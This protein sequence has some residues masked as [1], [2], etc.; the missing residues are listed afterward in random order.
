MSSRKYAA[1]YLISHLIFILSLGVGL[2][3]IVILLYS[4]KDTYELLGREK[5][6]MK[7]MTV[8][9]TI[10]IGSPFTIFGYTSPYALVSLETRGFNQETYAGKD[11]YFKFYSDHRSTSSSEI[12]LSARDQLGRITA[13]TCIPPLPPEPNVIIGPIL[14]SPT[15]SLDKLSYFISDNIILTGQAI[16]NTVVQLSLF[17][18]FALPPI[19]VQADEG[20]NYAV[21]LPSNQDDKY[22]I[23]TRTEFLDQSSPKSNTLLFTINPIWVIILLFIKSIWRL[24]TSHFIEFIIVTELLIIIAHR[25]YIWVGKRKHR[26]E[27]ILYQP[28]PLSIYKPTSIIPYHSITALTTR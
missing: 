9:A 20:G 11:G 4:R 10:G 17:K 14:L 22:R 28:E 3:A 21:T 19:E 23:F 18:S 2:L 7:D 16:P 6:I 13:Q 5:V 15:L 26:Y 1:K 8:S 27:M 12:C 25:L 24:L